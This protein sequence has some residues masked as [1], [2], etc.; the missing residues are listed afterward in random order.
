MRLNPKNILY[1]LYA[2][3]FMMVLT[4]IINYTSAHMAKGAMLVDISLITSAITLSAITLFLFRPQVEKSE[5][6]LDMVNLLKKA[7]TAANEAESISEGLQKCLDEICNY[8]GW[9]LGH[10]YTYSTDIDVLVSSGIYHIKDKGRFG[11]FLQQSMAVCIVPG[12]GFIGEVYKDSTPM[13]VMNV[14][15]SSIHCRNE[16]AN[17]AG[18]VVALAFPIFVGRNAVGV[19]EF[20]SEKPQI[21]DENMLSVMGNIGK[22]LGQV[23]ERHNNRE[24]M[25]HTL[26]ELTEA[27][28]QLEVSLQ[29]A[30]ESN[31]AKSDFLANMSH[32]LRTPMNGVLGMAHL[33]SETELNEEQMEYVAVINGSGESLLMLLNDILDFSKIEAKA[34]V[35][36]NIPYSFAETL[37]RTV[38]MLSVSAGNK[39]LELLV[40]YDDSIPSH[41]MGDPGRI[42]QVITNLL[43]NAI[44]FTQTGYVR[45]S[46][47]IND[48]D[49]CKCIRVL[50]EDTGVGIAE[51][52][53]N[54]VFDKFTQAD[55]SVTRKYGGTGLGLAISKQLIDMM[56]G[57]IGV[58]S[59]EGKGST[60]WFSIPCEEAPYC[61]ISDNKDN[62][63]NRVYFNNNRS[64][65]N[66]VRA[67]L[68]ED[69]P[70]NQAFAEKLLRKFGLIN[71]DL[72]E[73]GIEA[74]EKY[75]NNSY[76]IIFMDCQMPE[77]DGYQATQK[78]REMEESSPMHTPIIAMT[79]NA[80]MGDREK[81]LKC[82]M[83]DYISKPLRAEHLRAIL[84][85]LFILNES[86][87][88]RPVT[89]TVIKFD[90]SNEN[91]EEPVDMSQLRLFTDGDKEEER[92][93][94][95]LF[96]EQ[97]WE[98][99]GLLEQNVAPDKNDVWKSA[100]HRFKGSSGNLGA[101][102]LYKFCK[103][104]ED[105]F[106]A[107]ETSKLQMLTA[108]K[109]ETKRVEEFFTT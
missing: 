76:D 58:K 92:E 55:T 33:L 26:D 94:S 93:L 41:I 35:L 74:I 30:E 7:A 60:F 85:N 106:D 99:V 91:N 20:Y 87:G 48:F 72:A 37:H 109:S 62:K 57:E 75:K 69:Y 82:G 103:Q 64:N 9:P 15:S 14:G 84:N 79:A 68:V 5:A 71:I 25:Q 86:G 6:N 63:A 78:I 24:K 108:I 13:W 11:E 89:R 40:E 96:L 31:R 50:V 49:F 65:I 46:V 66:E 105:S 70:V 98:M 23:I 73:N 107:D 100:A 44:K 38:N 53:L 47:A 4:A 2:S 36:E 101:V 1:I 39:G 102:R 10:V 27:K 42:R 8:T 77:L 21:P 22:Q 59:V 19:M 90:N 67:L 32:E 34:L 83:D 56:G 16:A 80:M 88:A 3:I 28:Q 45:I 51:N 17:R 81:C 104:A 54:E 61:E 12:E 29:I 18:L 97:A 95:K 52:K 43:G